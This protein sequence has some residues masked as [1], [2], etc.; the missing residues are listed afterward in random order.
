MLSRS[1]AQLRA[2]AQ[3]LQ[4]L[5]KTSRTIVAVAALPRL[6]DRYQTLAEP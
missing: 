4:Q 5:A 2:R 6:A 3:D 1:A